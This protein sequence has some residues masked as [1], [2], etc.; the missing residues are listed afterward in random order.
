MNIMLIGLG[1]HAR[2]IYYPI[3]QE[4]QAKKKLNKIFI[5][6]LQSQEEIITKYLKDKKAKSYILITLPKPENKSLSFLTESIFDNCAKEVAGVIIA[7]EP[8]AHMVYAKWALK[9]GLNI[10]MDKPISTREGIIS[11]Q[12]KGKAL[13][14]DFN[15]LANLYKEARKKNK[16]IAFAIMA[17]RRF[18]KAF[19]KMKEMVREVFK[20]TNC[21]VTSIQAYHGDGQW[22]M[23]SEIIDIDYHSYNQG[24]GKCSHSGYHFFDIVSWL[25]E[26]GEGKEKK[27]DNFEAFTSFIQPTDLL[28]QLN[29]RDYEKIFKDF[30]T[31]TKYSEK[32]LIKKMNS[33][34]EVDAFCQF[35]FKK[36]ERTQT[37][38]SVNLSHNGFSQRGWLSSKGRDLYKGNGRVRH[39]SYYISQ[40]PF[41]AIIYSSFQSKEVDPN[42]QENIY[43]VGGEY[44]LDIYRFRNS[45]L[46]PNWKCVEKFSVKDMMKRKITDYSRGHQEDARRAM[47]MSFISHCAGKDG[48]IGMSD[49]LD[50][51]RSVKMMSGAYQSMATRNKVKVNL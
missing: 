33:C 47:V 24:Y 31:N 32:E 37:L 21:P 5:I 2:R 44:H 36:G 18:H 43:N 9:K 51:E 34:G 12:K 27:P 7:T 28:Q 45:S 20:E 30:K 1:Y 42:K 15:E 19:I 10:L 8:L 49:L 23:P 6:D 16:N 46:F 38:A 3:L 48:G 14:S 17:Q 22:R 40:G 41:Q 39:E 25:M 50:Y 11:D 29:F 4:L 26:A 13:I 35:A